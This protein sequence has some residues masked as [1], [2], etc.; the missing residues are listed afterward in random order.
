V[1][2]RHFAVAALLL[3]FPVRAE[4]VERIAAKVNRDIVTQSELDEMTDGAMAEQ[5][6]GAQPGSAPDRRKV[7]E[8]VL[9]RM[10]TDRLIVQEAIAQ[11]IK[12]TDS[13]VAPQV[14]TEIDNVRARFKTRAEF[15]AQLRK[16]GLT[17][18]DLRS[19]YTSEMMDRFLYLKMLNKRK[20]ELEGSID[21]TDP[22]VREYY[23]ANK[24]RTE[25]AGEPMVHARHI[26]F[27]V[28]SALTGA[29]RKAALADV[30]KKMDAAR[31]ALKRGDTF[32]EVARIFSEDS[33]TKGSGGDLGT[34]PKGTYHSSIEGP[35][36][37]LKPGEVSR[38]VES[39]LG[40]H[41][42]KVEEALPARPKG[43]DEKVNVPTPI[44]TKGGAVESGEIALSE[45]IRALI[46]NERISKA[47]QDWT[48]GLK[49]R[50]LIQRIP[51]G[52]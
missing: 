1:K 30:T 15:E 4:V 52:G 49:K 16:E 40:L 41:L 12:V 22:E 46:L 24:G 19:R 50:A 20:R 17:L 51:A 36:F 9:E 45:Y 11:G 48:E 31:A 25:W 32:D 7:A 13:E 43:L 2:A 23:E 5:S 47:L 26:L 14:D 34:F 10:I 28:D 33:A 27:A 8:Q 6:R 44:M 42:V 37:S 38:P 35:A 39:P 3:A 21:V 29:A 18:E